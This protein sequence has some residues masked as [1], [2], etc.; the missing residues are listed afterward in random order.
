MH[1]FGWLSERGG[2]FLN[3]LLKEGVP[4][5]KVPTLEE[6]MCTYVCS[7]NI[8]ESTYFLKILHNDQVLYLEQKMSMIF[9][10]TFIVESNLKNPLNVTV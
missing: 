1:Q 7:A 8:A 3:L 6:T 10:Q 9:S 5:E 2:N 4:S